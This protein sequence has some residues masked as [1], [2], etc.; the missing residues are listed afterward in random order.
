MSIP[1]HLLTYAHN[2][3]GTGVFLTEIE[4]VLDSPDM[5][6][7]LC[8]PLLSPG[9]LA[10]SYIYVGVSNHSDKLSLVE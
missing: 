1:A 2:L 5:E 8:N 10:V 4:S 6:N 3:E 7:F 9:D